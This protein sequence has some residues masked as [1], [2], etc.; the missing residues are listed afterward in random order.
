[1]ETRLLDLLVCPICK[2]PLQHCAA[3]ARTSAQELVCNADAGLPGAR[4]HPGD[5]RERGARARPRDRADAAVR[6]LS[7]GVSFDVLIPARLASTRLPG[8]PLADIGGVPMVV[9]VAQRAALSARS[10]VVVAA[11]D[12]EIVAACAAHGVRAAA[13]ARRPRQRQRPPGRGLRSCSASTATTIVVNVQGDEPLIEPALIDACAAL[14]AARA[15]CVMSTAA[16][17]ID[18]ARRL[19]EPERRQGRARRA[20]A[21]R[22]TSRARRFRGWRDGAPAG[23]AATPADRAAAPRR[24]LCLPRRASCA[25]FAALAPSPL[26]QHRGAGAAARAVARRAHRR[27]RQRPTRPASASTRPRIWRGRGAVRRA[28]RRLRVLPERSPPGARQALRL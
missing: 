7:A 18:D 20:R 27:A 6:A 11:D 12:A 1:M 22:C 21:A 14:L 15:D 5:A 26:E 28:R 10:A 17:P 3:A 8:K 4:R 25:R 16:H 19:R 23:D 13:D 24:A 2:G 9:R